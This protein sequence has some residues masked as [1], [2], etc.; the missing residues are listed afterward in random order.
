MTVISCFIL[1]FSVNYVY[2]QH[3]FPNGTRNKYIWPFASDS[4]WNHAIGSNAT[5][6]N[7]GIVAPQYMA[8]DPDY[9]I[10][11]NS[12]DPKI[13][14]YAPHSWNQRCDISGQ[15]KYPY[16]VPFPQSLVVPDAHSGS[17]P[18]FAAAILLPDGTNL[19][20]VEPLC[21]NAS[22]GPM[23]GYSTPG[24]SPSSNNWT[25][26][27]GQGYYGGHFGSGLSSIGGTIRLGELLPD[28][29]P[30]QHVL[31]WELYGQQYFYNDGN[32]NDCKRWPAVLCDSCWKTC[33][34]GKNPNLRMGSLLA[35]DPDD[36]NVLNESLK[37]EPGRMM[38]KA[39]TD[40]GAYVVDN[41][42]WNEQQYCVE[43][44]VSDQFKKAW[45]YG[46]DNFSDD[47]DSPYAADMI[48]IAKK[49][50]IVNNN[51]PNTIGGGGI[52]R[53]PLPP[54]IGN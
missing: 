27:Y 35:I 6:V 42:G 32:E 48:E 41:T 10:V 54:K 29:G 51:A 22:G 18:N 4:I 1:L 3:I 33:Y 11:T 43:I 53:Q 9:W 36:F 12:N 5:Y 20:Q 25:S 46:M 16:Q 13:D 15:T 21:R 37:T 28:A 50:K 44:G 26:I 49:F 52:L 17:T 2:G 31:K 38:L 24:E 40:Y 47:K 7:A 34:G 45:G 8:T 23:F 14:W 19:V 39:L 30:I